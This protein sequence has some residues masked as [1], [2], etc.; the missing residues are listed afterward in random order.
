MVLI[1]SANS[2]GRIP[3]SESA[4]MASDS[5]G[6]TFAD[7]VNERREVSGEIAQLTN[8]LHGHFAI[9]V[10]PGA[11]RVHGVHG[12]RGTYPNRGRSDQSPYKDTRS[13]TC[14]HNWICNHNI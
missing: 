6:L 9:T 7:L 4:R 13:R 10:I 8:L 1:F 5:R 14:S 2:L 12:L 11:H 3:T